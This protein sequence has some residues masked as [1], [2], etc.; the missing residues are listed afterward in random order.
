MLVIVK[1]E[2]K[3]K[4]KPWFHPK[5]KLEVSKVI[6]KGICGGKH[7]KRLSKAKSYQFFKGA[8]VY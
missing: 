3:E 2:K 6:T 4:K 7:E 5:V 1:K 8:D